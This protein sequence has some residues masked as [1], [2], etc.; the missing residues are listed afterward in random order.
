MVLGECDNHT[1]KMKLNPYLTPLTKSNWRWIKDLS[2][3][4][5]IVKLLEENREQAPC[6]LSWQ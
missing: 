5:E 2:I 6:H 4:L 1:R 3:Q